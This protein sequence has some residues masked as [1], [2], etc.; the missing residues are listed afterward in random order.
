MPDLAMPERRSVHVNGLRINYLDWGNEQAPPMVCVHG[1]TGSADA[2]NAFARH[3]RDRYHVIAPDVRG[4]GDSEW[5][6]DGAYQYADQVSDLAGFVDALGLQQFTLVGTSM[7]GIISM[8]YAIEQGDRLERLVINDIGPD[9]EA[10]SARITQNVGARPE[11]FASIEEAVAFRL[12]MSKNLHSRTESDQRELAAGILKEGANGRMQWKLDPRY[13]TDRVTKGAPARPALWPVLEALQCP[14]LVVWGTASDVLS[15]AQAKRMV[16][17][18]PKGELLPVADAE[19]AP[20][21]VEHDALAG[22]DKF[23]AR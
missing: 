22:L 7:G 16:S 5:S 17:A 14:T 21:L 12:S 9:A 1:Y 23:L 3:F 18:L 10:G 11:D 4:H 6:K 2:F 20:G 19:H 8:A 13:I 15:E